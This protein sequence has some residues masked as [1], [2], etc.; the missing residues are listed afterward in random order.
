MFSYGVKS[1]EE[2]SETLLAF[3]VVSERG[4]FIHTTPEHQTRSIYHGA[5]EYLKEHPTA[6]FGELFQRMQ[7]VA[8]SLGM[9]VVSIDWMGVSLL[10]LWESDQARVCRPGVPTAERKA[11]GAASYLFGEAVRCS[12]LGRESVSGD[13][14]VLSESA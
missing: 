10:A 13:V 2:K 12:V 5:I 6:S 3:T 14:A 4:D 8:E 1:V 9:N 7:P 11:K